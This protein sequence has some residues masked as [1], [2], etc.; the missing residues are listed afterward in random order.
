MPLCSYL[1]RLD[2]I[3]LLLAFVVVGA[4]ALPP[5]S[6]AA[7][8]KVPSDPLLEH[9][10]PVGFV[11]AIGHRL[12]VGT[13]GRSCAR[14]RSF[15]Q[16]ADRQLVHWTDRTSAREGGTDEPFEPLGGLGFG[17][18]LPRGLATAA[19]SAGDR[20]ILRAIAH[21]EGVARASPAG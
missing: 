5:A 16:C 9:A 20:R 10:V 6:T 7:L 2:E 8:R 3:D 17:V 4:E 13:V 15:V 11:A 14:V 21:A 1:D 18:R 12:T 19:P